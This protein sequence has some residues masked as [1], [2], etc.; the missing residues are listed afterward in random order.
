MAKHRCA[1]VI[2]AKNAMATLPKVVEK[3]LAQQVPWSYE[4]IVI[5]SG[6][7]DG[8]KE[9]LR[10]Q[11]RIRLIEIEPQE[12]GHGKTRNLGIAAADADLVAF[13]TH[14]AEPLNATWLHNLVAALEQSPDIAGAFGRHVA[15]ETASPFTKRDLEL[16]FQSILQ[17]PLIVYRDLEALRYETDEGWRQLLHFYS[18]NNSIMRKSV[19][20]EFPYPD[21]EFAEDQLW[22]QN[23]IEAGYKKAYA[24][25]AIVFHSHDYSY[26]EQL[27]RAFDESRNFHKYFGYK[28]SPSPIEALA[29]MVKFSLEAFRQEVDERFGVV[30]VGDRLRRAGQRVAL[31]AGHCLGA[32]HEKLPKSLSTQLSLDGRLFRT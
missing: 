7:S 5:D 2:P 3:A 9:Y 19:W 10:G 11:S 31:V 15:Y 1:I 28:L 24:H 25:D 32:N 30:T 14:D 27:R 16:H 4:I 29:K 17:H 12:F 6:S 13:L 23:I 18:D 26:S 20:N 21:V 22:A 8:T